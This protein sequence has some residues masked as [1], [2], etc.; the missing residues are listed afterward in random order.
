MAGELTSDETISLLPE[1]P[2]AARPSFD[3]FRAPTHISTSTPTAGRVT[4]GVPALD[5]RL[6][7]GFPK[8]RAIVVCGEPGTGKTT[9][10][11]QF[12][13]AG[14][15]AGE[16]GICVSVDQKPRHL[17]EDVAAFGWDLEKRLHDGQLTVLDASPYFTK[18]RNKSKGAMPVDVHQIATDLSQQISR[19]GARRLVIDSLTSLVPGDLTRAQTQ[20][21]LRSILLSVEDNLNCTVLVTCRLFSDDPQGICQ[22]TQFLSSGIIELRVRQVYSSCTRY[23]FIKKMRATSM[24]PQEYPF[25]IESS[26][27]IELTR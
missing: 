22:T 9:F 2:A 3:P 11:L 23:I 5:D 12:L 13:M 26:V 1:R 25:V 14:L 18:V 16:P 7:G 21:Y 15:Q 20:D 4:T 27:G 8:N 6:D 19:T 17:I 24:P 10:A